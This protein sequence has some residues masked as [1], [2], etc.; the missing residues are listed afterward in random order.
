M[1]SSFSEALSPLVKRL[2]RPVRDIEILRLV[3]N[4]DGGDFDASAHMARKAAVAWAKG[5]AGGELPKEAWGHQDFELLTGGRN[6]TG[7]RFVT[8]T[9]DLWALRAEDPDKT[10]P[11]RNWTTEIVIGGKRGERPHMSLRLIVSTAEGELN[12]EPHVP[13]TVLQ[14]AQKPGMLRGGRTMGETPKTLQ[15]ENDAHDL[16]DHLE[17]PERR[18]PILV[19]TLPGDEGARPMIDDTGVA[20]ALTGLARVVRVPAELTWVLT[21]RFGKFRSVFGG[22][23]RLYL[24]GFS[25]ADVPYRH[26][27]FLA[28]WLQDE[29]HAVACG[30][31]LRRTIAELSVSSSRLGKDVVEFSAVRTASRRLRKESLTEQKAPD[32]ELLPLAQEE[33]DSLQKQL[34][35]KNKEIDGYL[36]EIE[37]AEMRAKAAEQENRSLIYKIRQMQ[38][39]WDRSG[40]APTTEPSLPQEWAEFTDW[41]DNT[42]PDRVALT[43]AARR[44]V[45]N[46]EFEDVAQVAR[47]IAWL[48]TVQHSHRLTG[49]GS[50]REEWIE[51]GVKNAYCGGDMY[52]M[53]WKGRRYE[54][55]QHIKNGGNVRD[56]RRCLR[57][58]YFREPDIQQTVIDHLPAHRQTSAT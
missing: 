54:V 14:I 22:A 35:D 24:P 55:D 26:R 20:R 15:N 5:R 1:A 30:L 19:V 28:P 27:R 31:W 12:I 58:Y 56:P 7:V 39:A 11:G 17:E 21:K 57:I 46:L 45:S 16:C 4:L 47:A 37:N 8:D 42:Y 41:L 40:N 2:P 18:L 3:A 49:G 38:D 51:T 44:M 36:D 6:S 50:T 13:G 34:D 23:V 52:K 29:A 33:I 32:A 43:P 53:L 9:V 25:S 10:V 48:A